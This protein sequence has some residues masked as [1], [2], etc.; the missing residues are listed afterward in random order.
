VGLLD[1]ATHPRSRAR[2]GRR[3]RRAYLLLAAAAGLAALAGCDKPPP[4]SYIEFMEDSIAREGVL[5][6]CEKD[7][8]AS[9]ADIECANA[10]RA[11]VQIELQQERE[12]RAAYEKESERKLADL[13]A[14]IAQRERAARAAQAAAEAA[15][16][17]AYEAQW[18]HGDAS[19]PPRLPGNGP[20]APDAVPTGAPAGTTA[21]P[22]ASPASPAPADS[23]D[24]PPPNTPAV[25]TPVAPAN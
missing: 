3:P 11:A 23:L 19:T 16:K 22:A 13:R 24:T 6:R 9:A 8:D 17:A 25:P 18:E 15:A 12:R 5:A 10:R 2:L 21:P 1:V 7:G 4:R 14:Q 20:A